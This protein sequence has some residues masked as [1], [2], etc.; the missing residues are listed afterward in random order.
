MRKIRLLGILPY[1]ELMELVVRISKDFD[2]IEIDCYTGNLEEGRAIAEKTLSE[3]AYDMILSRA[4]TAELLRAEFRQIPVV[5]IPI[6]FEDVFYSVL[7]TR[8]YQEQFSVMCYPSLARAFRTLRTLLNYSFDITEIHPETDVRSHI[9]KLQETGITMIVGDVITTNV[10]KELGLNTI[11][12]LSGENSVHEALSSVSVLL[13]SF[14]FCN[15]FNES[16]VGK[17]KNSPFE[18]LVTD[19]KGNILFSTFKEKGEVQQEILKYIKESNCIRNSDIKEK[20]IKIGKQLFHIY[21][22]RKE[23]E[24]GISLYCYCQEIFRKESGKNCSIFLEDNI[25]DEGYVFRSAFGATNSVGKARDAVCY[26]AAS[27]LPVLILGEPGTGK[28]AAA[29]NIHGRSIYKNSPFFIIDCEEATTREWNRFFDKDSSPLY[30]INSVLFFKNIQGLAP[31]IM[32]RLQDILSSSDLLRSNKFIFS[33]VIKG[34]GKIPEFADFLL[35]RIHCILLQSLPV[36]ERKEELRSILV[37]YINEMNIL[38]GKQIAGFEPKAEEEFL[39]F[40]WPGNI[41]QV[42]RVIYDLVATA[43]ENFITLDAVKAHLRNE[44]FT[45]SEEY[46]Y[47]IDLSKTLNEINYDVVRIVMQQENSNQTK[48]AQRLGIGRATL[49]RILKSHEE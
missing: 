37:I 17:S 22:N 13:P 18:I 24:S 38:L 23:N 4:G 39:Q 9:Q 33:G 40:S 12:V 7:L 26:S 42:K 2:E 11:L 31:K 48:T 43:K 25:D 30:Y 35:N 27:P 28:D 5:E 41:T 32:K 3:K 14:R 44:I 49:W 6:S 21:F 47:N 34:D 16:I 20:N 8:S 45:H 36:R 46:T 29:R 15:D 19:E 10:A 1:R